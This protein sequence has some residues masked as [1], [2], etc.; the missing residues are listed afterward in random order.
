MISHEHKTFAVEYCKDFNER[1]AATVAG[2]QPDSGYQIKT[3]TAVKAAI[4]AILRARALEAEVDAEWLR[5]QGVE[6]HY[7]A[8]QQG[9]IGESTAALAFVA[10][11]A[12]VDAFAAQKVEVKSDSEIVDRLLRARERLGQGV[13]LGD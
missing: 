2:F 5:D 4:D 6:N 8:R 10:K 11:L 7:L 1:R 9:K 12:G 3:H 13:N